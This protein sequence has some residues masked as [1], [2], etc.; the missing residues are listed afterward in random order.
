MSSEKR[1]ERVRYNRKPDSRLPRDTLVT[2]RSEDTVYFGISR[3]N[4]EDRFTK[5]QGK[6]RAR[7][8]AN[9]ASQ[10]CAG[11]W[12]IND[13]CHLHSS[14]LMGKVPV[15]KVVRLLNYFNDLGR[16]FTTQDGRDN[17][18]L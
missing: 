9:V 13:G 2:F 12:K 15:D 8:R 11:N 6:T 5:E 17:R 10:N 4:P 16:H 7:L 1:D 14:G 18:A 3:C